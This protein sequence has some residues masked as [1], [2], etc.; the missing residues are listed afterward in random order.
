[1]HA[2]VLGGEPLGP[3]LCPMTRAADPPRA[4]WSREVQAD[5]AG[6]GAVRRPAPRRPSAVD[7]RGR[8]SGTDARWTPTPFRIGSVTK[9]FTAVLVMQCRDDGLLDLD[10]PIGAAPRRAG[11]RRR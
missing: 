7:V 9:T 1:M 3:M 10:D 5:G 8:R 6:P 4:G 2:H 11:A